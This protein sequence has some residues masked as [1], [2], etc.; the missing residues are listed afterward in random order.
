MQQHTSKRNAPAV[1]RPKVA[2][3]WLI[4]L[5]AGLVGSALWVLYPRDDLEQRL[6]AT[7]GNIELTESYLRNLLRSEPDNAQLQALLQRIE[8][9]KSQ[10][11]SAAQATPPTSL[12]QAQ[13]DAWK[14]WEA[15]Y[16]QFLQAPAKTPQRDAQRQDAVRKQ[17]LL[18][19]GALDEAQLLYTGQAALAL[20]DADLSRRS[21]DLL[22]QRASASDAPQVLEIAAKSALGNGM[23][24]VASRW[25]VEASQASTNTEAQK[26]TYLQ[27]AV[28]VLQ[29]GNHTA[30]ALELAE[31]ELAPYAADPAVLRQ[32]I[33]IARSAGRPDVAQRY[34]KQLLQLTLWEQLY[35]GSLS[36]H[37]AAN[38]ASQ[39][40]AQVFWDDEAP[41]RHPAL[42]AT[43]DRPA[44]KLAFDDKTYELGYTVFLEN[45]NLEDALRV[46]KAA[47]QQAPSNITWRRRLAQVAEWSNRPQEALT[48]WHIIAKQTNE[49]AAWQQVLRLAPGLLDDQALAD[50]LQYQLRR[51]PG[52]KRLVTEMVNTYERIGKPQ[53]AIAIFQ[54]LPH[55]SPE[56]SEAL[57]DL[58]ERAGEDEKALHQWE[59]LLQQPQ[60]VT[61]AR[62]TKAAI[63]AL[64]LGQGSKGLTWLRAASGQLPADSEASAD[65]LRL[66]AE[67]A[68]RHNAAPEAETAYQNL[69]RNPT[70]KPEDY[71]A[72]IGLL[73]QQ[74]Q[75]REAAAVAHMA[76][77]K[78]HAPRHFIQA[79]MLHG[80]QQDWAAATPLVNSLSS[81]LTP[82]TMQ[83]LQSDPL[84]FSLLGNYYQGM[85]RHDQARAMYQA[86]LKAFPDAADMRQ[87]L[88]WLAID[89][90]DT[91]VLKQMLAAHEAEWKQDPSMHDALASAYQAL[92]LPHIALTQYLQPHVQEHQNDFLWLMGYADA[93]EQN[94]QSDQAWR[95]RRQ[96]LEKEWASRPRAG[97]PQHAQL[98][99]WLQATGNDAVRRMA[100]NRLLMTQRPGDTAAASLRETLRLDRQGKT[101][102]SEAA[103]E[104]LISWYQEAG[105]YQ[106]VRAHLWERYSRQRSSN[107]PLW[108]EITTALANDDRA[109]AGQL[110]EQHEDALPR[111]DRINAAVLIG[112]TRRAQ[113]A[114][115]EAQ[116]HQPDD[117]QLNQQ[118]V[119]TLL[120]F[121][122]HAGIQHASRR[123]NELS[124]EHTTA[125]LHWAINPRWSIDLDASQTQRRSRDKSLLATTDDE[126]GID[127]YLRW[128]NASSS[129]TFRAGRRESLDTYTPLQL[130]WE[131]RI[132]NRLRLRL[133]AGHEL[134]TDE[135]TALR[136]GGMKDRLGVGVT[137]QPTRLDSISLDHFRDR[138]HLQT[139]AD[140]G[141]GHATTLQY[142]HALRSETPSLDV[143]AFWSTFS[144]S[145]RNLQS[146]SGRQLDILRYLPDSPTSV[147]A[148]YLLPESFQY[149]GVVIS[150]NQRFMEEYTR[151]VHPFAS[152]SLTRHSREGSGYG[153]SLGVAGSVWGQDH[154]SIGFNFSKSSPL[155]TGHTRELQISY[156]R[157]F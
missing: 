130:Q 148:N 84:Y 15:S 95:L 36:P 14:D 76:W 143:G 45:K 52:D 4:L 38:T 29:S 17:Q 131:Q 89:S 1:E 105:E 138:Y 137:Y 87:S 55:R 32:L 34:A 118:L 124:E 97:T 78:H 139:G 6:Q 10:Q 126:R 13:Q 155:A 25:Y 39:P 135:T 106:A 40:P 141:R 114:A 154:L 90:N 21:F 42:R 54:S 111:Y 122:D 115:F 108:A 85:R 140:I 44:P 77:D 79:L 153:L 107:L 121:S 46:A 33:D 142:M 113:S 69:L 103:T 11:Q 19:L 72:F 88:L 94:Q 136:M 150:T 43:A 26:K 128:K 35:P 16:N 157:H 86:G 75:S 57:A 12:Q 123:L 49:D 98:M 156:R 110:L 117:D 147:P 83:G 129:A 109:L 23:Y 37:W 82:E 61:P 101:Q 48:Q 28:A 74:G 5:L 59:S 47:V 8:K 60:A 7:Q 96:L 132:D 133:E 3:I 50:G 24:D 149:Y 27:G 18:P 100:R 145:E 102:L 71:D 146:L 66:Y 104:T 92:S 30:Q 144:F 120:S 68:D 80:Q 151:A 93:M 58:Y 41:E 65:F 99:Q 91:D 20:Q 112:D 152:L 70:A 63:L 134:P 81:G 53:Q 22:L 125:R 116:T 51:A 73:R 127:A 56:Q 9:E 62:A 119:E 2:P 64:R 67:L 31:K